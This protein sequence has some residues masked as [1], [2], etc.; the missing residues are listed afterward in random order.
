MSELLF[1]SSIDFV[2]NSAFLRLRDYMVRK[3]T[4]KTIGVFSISLGLL[5]GI[6]PLVP[7]ILLI[8]VGLELLGLREAT[9]AK[10]KSI[11]RRKKQEVEVV[12]A[13]VATPDTV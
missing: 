3:A 10:V 5:F 2:R 11:F 13:S 12:A 6:L 7:G 4:R 8:L 9:I 1:T